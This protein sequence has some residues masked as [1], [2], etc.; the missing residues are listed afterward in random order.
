MH[1]CELTMKVKAF[2]VGTSKQFAS[3]WAARSPQV[4]VAIGY[5][6]KEGRSS[7]TLFDTV[8]YRSEL[9][10]AVQAFRSKLQVNITFTHPAVTPGD[11]HAATSV[12]YERAR[13]LSPVPEKFQETTTWHWDYC[14]KRNLVVGG[15]H[16]LFEPDSAEA[17][18]NLGI[19]YYHGIGV[20]RSFQKAR[21]LFELSMQRGDARAISG[22]GVLYQRGEGVAQDVH[23]A[24]ELYEMAI[25]RGDESA[26][27]HL[28]TLYETG[29]GVVKDVHRAK[30]LYEMG[31]AKGFPDAQQQLGTLYRH[32]LGVARD[33][34]K[35]WELF[36]LAYTHG[37]PEAPVSLGY[38][39][40]GRGRCDE[41]LPCSQKNV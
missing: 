4:A 40:Q 31:S 28:G 18:N 25:K 14:S 23:R 5:H 19:M 10:A 41:K 8:F 11:M 21:E 30:D 16:R 7:K 34:Q 26:L 1:A 29:Q 2:W 36:H 32:G 37:Y 15:F 12:I 9:K 38:M 24:K 22:L 3:T 33:F 39:Y 6:I 20:S 35:A 27:A 17:F 13:L